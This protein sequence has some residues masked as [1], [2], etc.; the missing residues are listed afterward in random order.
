MDVVLRA[1]SGNVEAH[2]GAS[3]QHRHGTVTVHIAAGDEPA[4][5]SID[6]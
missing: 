4:V 2:T 5:E 3:L 1:Q 6:K